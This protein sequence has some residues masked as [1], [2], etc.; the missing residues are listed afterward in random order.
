[1]D[2][3]DCYFDSGIAEISEDPKR[4]SQTVIQNSLNKN[5]VVGMKFNV[6]GIPTWI[7]TDD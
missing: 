5:G 3:G 2:M 7:T 1:M 6:K 4:I